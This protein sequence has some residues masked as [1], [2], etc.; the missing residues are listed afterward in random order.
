MA[1]LCPN[2]FLSL[3]SKGFN[4]FQRKNNKE[5]FKITIPWYLIPQ[6]TGNDEPERSPLHNSLTFDKE[7][8]WTLKQTNGATGFK[9]TRGL[10]NQHQSSR[11]NTQLNQKTVFYKN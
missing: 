1:G 5:Y 9:T 8:R 7:K 11:S 4:T 10:K 2:E 6:I 3:W